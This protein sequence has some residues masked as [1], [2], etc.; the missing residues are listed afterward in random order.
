[1]TINRCSG[2]AWQEMRWL[3]EQTYGRTCHLCGRYIPMG[4]PKYH[5]RS[6][7]ADHVMPRSTHPHLEVELANLRPACRECNR[8]RSD[9]PLTPELIV[10]IRARYGV[11]AS[12]P[13]LNFF[14]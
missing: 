9:R 6:F 2:H 13:A 4:L 8:Y 3:V 11:A 7:E 10:E 12:R 1:M 14:D 5:R